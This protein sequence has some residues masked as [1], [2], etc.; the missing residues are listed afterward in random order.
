MRLIPLALAT[1][2]ALP[3]II[4]AQVPVFEVQTAESKIHFEVKASVRV[5]GVFDK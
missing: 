2:A 4:S 3:P 5:A 1:V